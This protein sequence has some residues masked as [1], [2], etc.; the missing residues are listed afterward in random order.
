MTVVLGCIL[1]EV[2][3]MLDR[4]LLVASVLVS[5]LIG[6]GHVRASTEIRSEM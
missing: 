3:Q 4:F 6:T 2:Q 5:C 1:L